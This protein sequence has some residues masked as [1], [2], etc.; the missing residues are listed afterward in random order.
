MGADKGATM[1]VLFVTPGFPPDIGGIENVVAQLS[2]E[3][4]LRGNGVHVLS[5]TND[6]NRVGIE[7]VSDLLTV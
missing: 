6:K 3:M 4:S 2:H 5:T 7:R 1:N